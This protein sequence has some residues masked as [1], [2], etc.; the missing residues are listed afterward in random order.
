MTDK[1]MQVAQEILP[2]DQVGRIAKDALSEQL[3]GVVV[4][5]LG[6]LPARVLETLLEPLPFCRR[7]RFPHRLG[8]FRRFVGCRHG[9][10]P[11]WHSS[12]P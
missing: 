1:E 3:R 9:L 12:R 6:H 7:D 8:S 2:I 4:A 5:L 10:Q 11:A